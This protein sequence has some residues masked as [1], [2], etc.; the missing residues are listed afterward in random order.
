MKVAIGMI[1]MKGINKYAPMHRYLA[2]LTYF[3]NCVFRSFDKVISVVN[4]RITQNNFSIRH[5]Y[6]I[7]KYNPER[8]IIY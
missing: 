4:T 3:L 8:P 5:S 2:I 1:T 7:L 6:F